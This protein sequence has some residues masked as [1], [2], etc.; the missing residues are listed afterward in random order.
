[1]SLFRLIP[2]LMLSPVMVYFF[3]YIRRMVRFWFHPQ[4]KWWHTALIILVCVALGIVSSNMFTSGIVVVMHLF[5]LSVIADLLHLILRK[6]KALHWW[7]ALY[8][9][10]VL[11]I[12][13]TIAILLFAYWNMHSVV[14]KEY[15]IQTE[16]EIREEGYQVVFISDL[17]IGLS[18]DAEGLQKY[19]KEIEALQP[20]M[21]LLGGD[22]VDEGTTLEAMQLTFQI[23]GDIPSEFGTYYVYG[24]H[25][26]SNDWGECDY[27]TAQLDQ[28]MAEGGV[29]VLSDETLQ[30]TDDF[31]LVGRE[32][33]SFG[34]GR[35]RVQ[36][37]K[38]MESVRQDDFILMLDHQP[39]DLVINKNL[40]IDLQ[41][42]GH[43]HAGQI[44]PIGQISETFEINEMTY[45]HNQMEDFQ[46]IVS[47]GMAGWGYPFR[48]SGHSEYLVIDIQGK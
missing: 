15:T 35:E 25:D 29:Q 45:G 8:R 40:G 42:S 32:D 22:I 26:R 5:M 7:P 23:L 39:L 31:V 14:Q 27:T 46:I 47:S 2:V 16:K 41:L 12:A 33:A 21:V 18:M 34:G 24:N 44:W 28:A 36:S 10:G 37:A 17:H 3:F 20:D 48:T 1:M 30:L 9:S 43:T 19:A 6:I 13:A 11:P 4:W 38:L